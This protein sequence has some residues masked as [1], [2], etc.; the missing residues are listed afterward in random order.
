MLIIFY[1]VLI[2]FSYKNSPLPSL[3][4]PSAP[5]IKKRNANEKYY[6]SS[7]QKQNNKQTEILVECSYWNYTY[8]CNCFYLFQTL[9]HGSDRHISPPPCQSKAYYTWSHLVW[10]CSLPLSIYTRSLSL[11]SNICGSRDDKK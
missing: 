10:P 1:F 2:I 3:I 11:W 9:T 6:F 5:V 4:F 8:I 7:N